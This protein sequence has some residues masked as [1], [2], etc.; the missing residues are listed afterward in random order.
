M[1]KNLLSYALVGLIGLFALSSCGGSTQEKTHPYAV[2]HTTGRVSVNEPIVVKLTDDAPLKEEPKVG[3]EVRSDLIKITPKVKGTAVWA[4]DRTIVFTPEKP[5]PFDQKFTVQVN[6]DKLMETGNTPSSFAFEINTPVPHFNGYNRGLTLYDDTKPDFYYLSGVIN[7]TAYVTNEQAEKMLTVK[8][9]T[10]LSAPKWTHNTDGTM[11]SYVIDSIRSDKSGYEIKFI[12]SGRPIGNDATSEDVVKVPK[13]GVFQLLGTTVEYEPELRAVLTFSSTVGAKQRLS[14]YL[15]VTPK[16]AVRMVSELNKIYIY[17]P[18]NTS[19]TFNLAIAPGLSNDRGEKLTESWTEKLIFE[20]LSPAVRFVGKGSIMPSSNNLRMPFQAVNFQE[21]EVKVIRIFKNNILQFLQESSL[22]DVYSY[23]VYRV[24]R[25][26]ASTTISLGDSTSAKLRTWNTYSLDLSTL[27]KADPGAIY[28]VMIRG[29][30]S[31]VEEYD[32]ED[33]YYDTYFG[34]YESRGERI[35]NVLASD[36]GI[37]AKKDDQNIINVYTT[38]LITA[39]PEKGIEVKVYDFVNQLIG[40]GTSDGNGFATIKLEREPH[41]VVARKGD[42]FGYLKVNSGSNLSMSEFDVSGE[43]VQGG[44]KGFIYGERGVWR[45]GDDIFLSFILM[46]RNHTLPKDHPVKLEFRDPQGQTVTTQVKTQAQDGLYAFHLTTAPEALTGSYTVKISVGNHEFRKNLR[47]ETIKPNRLKI[48]MKLNDT[49]VLQANKIEGSIHSEWL[50]GAKAPG[51]EARV[52]MELSQVDTKFKGYADYTFQDV[53]KSFQSD[54]E[55]QIF[56]G[57]LD[58]DG[59][60]K[61]HESLSDLS[62]APGMLKANITTR[63]FEESGDFSVDYYTTLC[64]PYS[65]YVGLKIPEGSGY[66]RQLATDET[67]T[68]KL[69]TLLPDGKLTNVKDLEVEIMRMDWVW[70]WYSSEDG[71]ADYA[72]NNYF[73]ILHSEKLTT[74]GGKAEF[75]YKWED[76]DW[77]LYLIKV[78]DPHS[79]HS[80][81]KI[82]YV[83]WPW[84]RRS[85]DGEAS[86]A[87]LLTLKSDKESYK[88]GETAKINIPSAAGARALVTLESGSKVLRSSWHELSAG[89]TTIPVKIEADMTPN[90]YVYVTL[91]QPHGNTVNDAPIRLYGVLSLPVEDPETRLNPVLSLPAE[92]RPETEFTV[93]VKEQNGK[94]MSYTLAI[95]D[96]GLLDLTRFKTPDPWSLFFAR[97]ALGVRT[98]DLYDYVIGAYGGRIEQ[99]FSIGGDDELMDKGSNKAQRFKPVVKFMGPFTL[100]RGKTDQH[101]ITLPPYVGAVRAMVVASS[102]EGVGAFGRTEARAQVKKPL[103]L[104][105]TLPRVVGTDEEIQVPVTVFAMDKTVK[106]VEVSLQQADGFEIE[107]SAKQRLTFTS[108]GDQLVYFRLKAKSKIGVGKVKILATTTGDQA[109]ETIEID[110]RDPNPRSSTS[111]SDMMAKGGTLNTQLKLA[112]RVGTNNATL[113]VSTM[114]PINLAQRLGYLLS[115]PH[116]CL[117]QTSSI[118][119]PQLFLSLVADTDE[120][121]NK[122][123]Q[124]NVKAA[125]TKLRKFR[126]SNGAFSYWPGERYVSFWANTFA[127]HFIVEADRL[128]YSVPV[129]MKNGWLEAEGKYARE[130]STSSNNDISN[131]AY[132]L[133]VL[134][135]A[136]V[137]EMGAMNRLREETKNTWLGQWMLAGAYSLS[138]RND[139]AKKMIDQLQMEQIGTAP[140]RYY[141]YGSSERDM[142]VVLSVL[143]SMGESAKAF[144]LVMKLSE[145]LN[146]TRWLGTQTTAWSLMSLAHYAEKSGKSMSFTYNIAGVEGK[147]TSTKAVKEIPI[148]VGDKAGDI[149]VRVVNTG[150]DQLYV[151]VTSE[152]IPEKGEEVARAENISV[153]VEY[154]LPNGTPMNPFLVPQGTDFFAYV[155]IHHPG[156]L[157]SYQDMVLSQIFP[158]GWEIRGSGPSAGEI[159][160]QDIRDDR[161]YTYFNLRKAAS[162]T[163][164]TSLTATYAGKF[165]KPGVVCEAMYDPAVYASTIGAW[166]EVTTK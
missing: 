125:I 114:P 118:A 163:I 116:G 55:T 37:I 108:E 78:T 1:M 152:G 15:T 112:G 117:E 93:S 95:V 32:E 64:S 139:I 56:S 109:Q 48:D 135:L 38:N 83:D 140:D 79:G 142:A 24:G 126:T 20:E 5:L 4:E 154:R 123:S 133:Y 98:W 138:G 162:I 161:V 60:V 104:M 75:S 157:N 156:V 128:G 8:S 44:I 57:K 120:R 87:T 27:I 62:S 61:F 7:T 72:H 45:P 150:S 63:V 130:W 35:R 3:E 159:R 66:D 106:Q 67:H 2:D 73:E 21:V 65:S 97:E 70:W 115:Y 132:R 145:A 153:K 101:T 89:S 25:E 143:H 110:V 146:S 134:A 127:G 29:K 86:A 148:E 23:E 99:L 52:E 49:P 42:Q 165:Y 41:V 105:T 124:E 160:Y 51:L 136:G 39:L 90:I 69:V 28:R 76:N 113:E 30:K 129:D 166:S 81:A 10:K 31:L 59:N 149:S 103:M 102:E 144:P 122:R 111:I 94:A 22:T 54:D 16:L 40:E 80:V 85:Q 43:A 131:Q 33:Y 34:P 121:T 96:E 11:H 9:S 77:G 107:G 119:F 100:K 92:I 13:Q 50:H 84:S 158:S 47:I 68:F 151:R 14:E 26:V 91:I 74:V 36:L 147:A 18:A 19:G 164:R 82:C 17:P 88:V 137:P 155:T 58:Q 141:T 46:D 12:Y 53:S 6:M 71:F